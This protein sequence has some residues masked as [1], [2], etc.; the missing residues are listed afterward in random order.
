MRYLQVFRKRLQ[1]GGVIPVASG[2]YD[3][4]LTVSELVAY[5]RPG[6]EKRVTVLVGPQGRDEQ[7]E[8]PCH[9]ERGDSRLG[10]V[11]T[12]WFEQSVVYSFIYQPELGW[13]DVQELV[14]F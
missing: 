12:T 5:K 9:A 2:T 3:G 1:S 13:V 7:A 8:R 11:W 4:Q 10:C 14:Y 6:S